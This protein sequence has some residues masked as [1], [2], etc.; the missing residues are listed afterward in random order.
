MEP[1]ASFESNYLLL[2]KVQRVMSMFHI[3]SCEIKNLSL[4]L[5]IPGIVAFFKRPGGVIYD[6]FQDFSDIENG[7]I[8]DTTTPRGLLRSVTQVF[9]MVSYVTPPGTFGVD[10][11]AF[12]KSLSSQ[13]LVEKANDE[14]LGRFWTHFTSHSLAPK[15]QSFST[16][17]SA[18][19]S[20]AYSTA[21]RMNHCWSSSLSSRMHFTCGNVRHGRGMSEFIETDTAK[22]GLVWGGVKKKVHN[23]HRNNGLLCMWAILEQSLSELVRISIGSHRNHDNLVF[24]EKI[25]DVRFLGKLRAHRFHVGHNIFV[26]TYPSAHEATSAERPLFPIVFNVCR[27]LLDIDLQT[28]KKMNFTL[29][30]TIGKLNNYSLLISAPLQRIL[31]F[32]I[33]VV[34]RF[35]QRFES[36]I[37]S[38]C[39]GF[40][41][42]ENAQRKQESKLLVSFASSE[43]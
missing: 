7:V 3:F 8:Y 17:W 25:K 43:I 9:P 36:T 18:T 5:E 31:H 19:S 6:N 41:K 20:G 37:T 12:C 4:T 27:L 15:I 10:G 2:N 38:R 11:P 39:K 21:N 33:R 1:A 23:F 29:S 34:K 40:T 35:A 28:N 24:E 42:K 26:V 22:G 30:T 14:D 32:V 13:S 16:L